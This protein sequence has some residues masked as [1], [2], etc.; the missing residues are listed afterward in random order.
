MI[1]LVAFVNG[2]LGATALHVVQS[3][4][5]GVVLNDQAKQRDIEAVMGNIPPGIPL[6]EGGQDGLSSQIAELAPT[7]GLSVLF[8]HIIRPDTLALF[9]GGIAN[10]HPSFLPFGRGAHP[11]AWAIARNEPTGVTLHLID[12]GVDTGAIL[13]QQ[14]V[15]M[16]LDDTAETLY[17]RLMNAA[18]AM[19]QQSVPAWLAGDLVPTPQPPG[20]AARRV[21][22]LDRT[23]S[24][25]ANETYT[26]RALVDILRARTFAHHGATYYADG[27]RFRIRITIEEIL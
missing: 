23:L 4:L 7:H 3:W 15:A 13:S 18:E 24:I 5:V 16:H 10:L 22:D 14:R 20:T 19:L 8:G 27:R 2:R 9:P 12:A 11:N 26:G 21:S 25:E 6:L 17:A 1:R